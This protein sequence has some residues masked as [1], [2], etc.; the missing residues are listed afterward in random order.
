M[1]HLLT[2][3]PSL[4]A[5]PSDY[6]L[7]NKSKILFKDSDPGMTEF[8]NDTLIITT[9]PNHSLPN[10]EACE[11]IVNGSTKGKVLN[12][13]GYPARIPK[14]SRPDLFEV[15]ST[16]DMGVGLFAKRNIKRGDLILAERPLLVSP[17]AV[18]SLSQGPERSNYTTRQFQQVVMFE[19]ESM[20]EKVIER[21]SRGNQAAFRALHNAHTGDG[22]GPLLGIIRSNGYGIGNL[23]DGSDSSDTTSC[24]GAVCKIGS[25]INH[26]C[27]SLMLSSDYND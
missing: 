27:V 1:S 12:A 21:L 24:Y 6:D 2:V 9:V 16:L 22:S 13:P 10:D 17:R 20:L 18:S 8:G 5:L 14:P 19:Y 7:N 11:W 26:R 3:V 23:Y 25:R 4:I 15:R